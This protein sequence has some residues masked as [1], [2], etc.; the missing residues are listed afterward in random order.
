M[1]AQQHSGADHPI[2]LDVIDEGCEMP[3]NVANETNRGTTVSLWL[4]AIV[5][6][7]R[8]NLPD[9]PNCTRLLRWSNLATCF[10]RGHQV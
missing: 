7:W 9:R 4:P 1:P 2:R 3:P 10:D 6:G 5:A 8:A